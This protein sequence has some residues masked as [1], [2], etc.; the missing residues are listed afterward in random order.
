VDRRVNDG[1]PLRVLVTGA[2][3]RQGL[4]VIRGLGRAGHK[5][6]A[7]GSEPDSIG[8]ASRYATEHRLYTSPLVDRARCEDDLVNMICRHR[9]DVVIPAVEPTLVVLNHLRAELEHWTTLAAP[10]AD[11]LEYALDKSKTLRLA[12][13]LEVPV[14]T[15]V[16]GSTVAQI[17]HQAADL[18]F[19]V[20][21][22]PRGP[23]LH[24]S[25]A[26]RTSFTVS[27]ARSLKELAALL[28]PMRDEASALLVQ[29]FV[30]G[31]GRCVAAVFQQGQPLAL[32][33]YVRVRELPH[34][35]GVSVVRRSE[36]LDERLREYTIA[37]LG[38]IRWHGVAMVEYRYDRRTDRFTLMEING[39]FQTS[40]ALSL[41]ANLN[42]PDMV[43][44]LF[45][46]RPLAPQPSYRV[47]VTERWLRGDWLALK[48]ALV[49]R[50]A[51]HP[52]IRRS[53]AWPIVW[54]FLRDFR[55]GVRL[56]EFKWW[57]WK[58][59][60]IEAG[61]LLGALTSWSGNA[62]RRTPDYAKGAA[63]SVAP[64]PAPASA[65]AA[66]PV[67]ASASVSTQERIRA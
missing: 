57:D 23:S 12:E 5:V 64:A 24:P 7:C 27:Y 35:G 47:G 13:R 28:E 29:E 42:L 10:P 16:E 18:R 20:A 26:H 39:R 17:L 66:L 3:E 34:S 48:D 54:E 53:S 6:I 55:P 14:P 11:T 30:P 43:A 33:P 31:V 62:R 9:P 59:G 40:V 22:K 52:D 19:P 44:C 50:H 63:S 37:L 4:S 65:P 51:A 60:M 38:A 61:R 15:S 1:R 36:A 21:V 45:A 32:F 8:F 56:D 46:G 2:E 25:T 58:P 49:T 41:D 67:T